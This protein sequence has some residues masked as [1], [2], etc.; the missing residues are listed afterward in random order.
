MTGWEILGA[1]DDVLAKPM[2]VAARPE[3]W[4][5]HAAERIVAVIAEWACRTCD[6]CG[7]VQRVALCVGCVRSDST[8]PNLRGLLSGHGKGRE[9]ARLTR[10]VG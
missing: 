6:A 9:C 4:D 2:P 5:G 7:R 3:L 8:Q 1:V 10:T